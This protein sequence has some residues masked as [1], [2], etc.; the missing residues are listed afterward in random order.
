MTCESYEP[1][2]RLPRLRCLT[3][4]EEGEA[5]PTYITDHLDDPDSQALLRMLDPMSDRPDLSE[6]PDNYANPSEWVAWLDATVG[7]RHRKQA[8][9][10]ANTIDRL[11]EWMGYEGEASFLNS[12]HQMQVQESEVPDEG[13]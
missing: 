1:N 4:G 10:L 12:L 3:C 2:P 7:D 5:H 11:L 9:M 6:A 8:Y 13:Q